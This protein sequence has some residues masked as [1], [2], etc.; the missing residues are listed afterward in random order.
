MLLLIVISV[1][2]CY[3]SVES[4]GSATEKKFER[5]ENE[6]IYEIA[7]TRGRMKTGFSWVVR[8]HKL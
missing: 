3:N 6:V 5:Y 8:K 4:F 7:T 2:N 1:E